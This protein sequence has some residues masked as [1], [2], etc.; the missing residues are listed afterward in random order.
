MFKTTSVPTPS[1]HNPC[2]FRFLHLLLLSG[3]FLLLGPAAQAQTTASIDGI[4]RDTDGA[5]VP[6]AT[7]TLVSE[8]NKAARRDTTSNGEGFFTINAVQADT[9]DLVVTAKN[10]DKF[11]V[12]G[13]TIHPGDHQNV[14]KIALKVGQISEEI[15]ISARVAGVNLDSPEKSSVI[16]ADDIA[17]LSTVGRDASELIRT[18][19]GFAVSTGGSLGNISTA[20]NSQQ[21][22]FGS[23]SVSSF[24]ANGSTPQTGATQ[25]TNDGAN[26]TDPG[27][28]GA[29]IGNLNIDMVQEVKVSTS[30]FGADQANGPV[31]IQAVGKSGGSSYHGSAYFTARNSVLNSNDWNSNFLGATRPPT[32]YY[33]PGANVGGPVLIPGT[34]FN[35]SRK[36]TFFTAFEYYDQTSF[37]GLLQSFIPTPAM[38][39]GDLTPGTI[40]KALNVSTTALQATCPNDYTT[41]GSNGGLGTLA[42]SGGI[43]FSPGSNGTT[44]T[45]G[46]CLI[47]AGMIQASPNNAANCVP[48]LPPVDPHAAIYAKF[49]PAINRVPKAGN[50]FL[51]DG[52]NY[53]NPLT[54]T[55]N[56]YQYRARVD[57]NFT[58]TLKLYVT[59]NFEKINDEITVDNVYYAG[60]DVIP[61]PNPAF[62][63]AT[64]NGV[65]LNVTK[66]FGPTLTNELIFAGTLFNSPDQ[67][68]NAA[69]VADAST[70]WT[71]GRYYNNGALQLP[72]IR[73]YEEGVPDFAMGYFPPS[74]AFLH[75]FSFDVQENLTKQLRTHTIKAGF[76][77]ALTANNQVPYNFTQGLYTFNH[78]NAG[79]ITNDGKQVS[80]LQNNVANLDEGC[81]SFSQSSSSLNSDLHFK[82]LDFYLTDDWKATRRLT[83]QYGL[84]FT[85]L[86]PWYSPDGIG[87]AVWTPPAQHQYFNVTQD[88]HTFPGISWKQTNSSDPISGQ[89]SNFLFYSPRVG[90]SYDL[91]GNGKTTL[92]GGWGA[93]RF[94]DS[95]NDSD[96]PLSTV[97]GIQTYNTPSNISCTYAQI[98]NEGVNDRSA[99][100]VTLAAGAGCPATSATS[101]SPFAVYAFDPNDH[102]QPVTYNYNFTVDQQL[103]FNSLLELSYVGNQS[104]DLFTEG[105]LSNQNYIP[106]GGLFQP[107]PITGQVSQA[108]S[109]QQNVQDYRPYPNYSAVYV[110]HHIGY[111]NY[112]A[113]QASWNKQKGKFIYGFNYTWAK[114]LGIRGD[115][116]TGAVGDPSTLVHNY[117]YLGFNRN[118]AVNATYSYQVGQALHGNRLVSGVVNNW[119]VSGIV[120]LQ[121][122]PDVAVLNGTSNTNFNLS[123][124]AQYTPAGSNTPIVVG[125]SN[126]TLL[127]TPDINLQP[128]VSCDPRKSLKKGTTL[129]NQYI[130]GSCFALPSLG[131]NGAWELPDTH[132][133]AYFDT[134][135]TVARNFKLT[136]HQNLQF[137]LAGFN[138][139]N[140]PLYSFLSSNAGALGL[141]FSGTGT[142]ATTP[143]QAFAGVTQT[144]T[145]FGYTPYK[146][147]YR[148][149]SL[150]AKYN[151]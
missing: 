57:E 11:Q 76:Y 93:Y 64:S 108:G 132:G 10:F 75:K 9:Y 25:V 130:N 58:D 124:G 88:P 126:T 142:T 111:G 33:Y 119:E 49:W 103:F 100:P 105:N 26:V 117:G 123:G 42:N 85:H 128:V 46:D 77:G 146:Q 21:A 13:I 3:L 141:T 87:L 137:K 14:S 28:E 110:P 127:G 120:T 32:Q 78:Y 74:S 80:Q 19:P 143:A 131:S 82:S 54:S 27:D 135:I 59:Y 6:G 97:Q 31:V 109:S 133:P 107:D 115:Y 79:C 134:D 104:H 116:R 94:H 101:V 5:L 68:S 140:H 144:S 34:N 98:Q 35:H 45:Q 65:S 52:Y 2:G 17:R 91:Y 56:G 71:G 12:T 139:L 41:N 129:G 151:F 112:N 7:V 18:L 50:G 73:D 69:Q 92:R 81:G 61:Y 37:D 43:C 90:L 48:G 72:G 60:S 29:S 122:G 20:N 121:S 15:T 39:A 138:F 51:S 114:A 23:S 86:G 113:L 149:V 95:Y 38:L 70:G 44:Y 96:G 63:H 30:N 89:S 125:L 24:S 83:L 150:E 4:V 55:H 99:K 16:T 145:N 53:I 136:E 36:L 148:I 84:R 8:K 147:G 22:G 106:L 47:V 102:Q 66:S 67:L 40:A 1:R 62:T 118:N